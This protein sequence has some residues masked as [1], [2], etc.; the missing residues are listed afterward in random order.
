MSAARRSTLPPS[1]A[2]ALH[3]QAAPLLVAGR[4]HPLWITEEED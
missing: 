4:V 2:K 3:G 1:T